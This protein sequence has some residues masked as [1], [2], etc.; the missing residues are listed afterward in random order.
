MPHTAKNHIVDQSIIQ[1]LQARVSGSLLR[2]DSEGYDEACM[3]WNGRYDR[4]P[5]LL[6]QPANAA[7]V[8]AV[9]TFARD[10]KLQLSVRCGGHSATGQSVRDEGLT[11]DLTQMKDITVDPEARIV[12]AGGGVLARDLGQATQEH[13][14][15]VPTGA[16]STI[17]MGGLTTGGGFGFLMRKYGLTLDSLQSVEIVTADGQ[18][19]TASASEHPDL[20]W[21]VRGGSGNFGVIMTFTYQAYPID[22]MV[23]S[24]PLVYTLDK[25]PAAL[26]HYRE[27]M[28][29]APDELTVWATFTTVPP[30]DPFPANLHGQ[31]VL[32]LDACYAGDLEEGAQ[33]V[34]PLRYGP[35]ADLDLLAPMPYQV[36]LT[37]LDD[38]AH[39]GKHHD[40]TNMF[41]SELSDEAIDTLVAHIEQATTPL[42]AVQVARIG[43][44]VAQVPAD[45]TAFAHRDA[46]YLL[47]LPVTWPPDDDGSRHQQW[48]RQ[49]AA[50]MQPFSTGGA[51]VNTLGDEGDAGIRCAY[52]P[53][54]YARLRHI[55][56]QY[57]PENVFRSNQNILPDH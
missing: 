51:Y 45:T 53:A 56:R 6:V 44:A 9:V 31:M 13:G 42:L 47:W 4:H 19:R 32:M 30:V 27:V 14:L 10:H 8:A 24:G 22:T 46:P 37:M 18:V 40:T 12:H 36:R 17:G 28:E 2:P 26:R 54:T 1:S 29:N 35:A 49:L 5:A 16:L 21:A 25:A 41:L 39:H 33:A 20:F 34:Q 55:K 48:M 50:A 57:D 11:I 3:L 52:P 43:G 23:L 38:M 7:D 15:A